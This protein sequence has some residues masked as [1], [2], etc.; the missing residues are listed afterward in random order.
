ML[1]QS[2]D[3]VKNCVWIRIKRQI[4]LSYTLNGPSKLFFITQSELSEKSLIIKD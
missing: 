3:I 4:F 2:R 1:L